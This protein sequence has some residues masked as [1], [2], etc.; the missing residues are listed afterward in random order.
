[1]IDGWRILL[2]AFA[3]LAIGGLAW[4]RGSL[5]PGGWAGAVLVGTITFG[6]GGWVWGGLLVGFFVSSS[7][8]T[9]WRRAAKQR[10][11]GARVEKGGRRDLGQVLANGGP[12]ALLA[13]AYGLGGEPAALLWLFLGVMATVTADTWATEI[14]M[15]DPAPPRLIIGL[16]PVSAGTSGAIS[17]YG[18][19]ATLAGAGLIG[20][21]A[22]LWPLA[23][24]RPPDGGLVP[25]ALLGG[26]AGSLCD[27]LLGAT[28]QASY[29]G[30]DG[31]TER[32]RDAH[33]APLPRLRGVPGLR[34]D[35]VNLLSSLLGGL[36]G[37]LAGAWLA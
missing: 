8:L 33:G 1:M 4:W 28:L 27:S 5:T 19:A 31:P 17:G 21:I 32:P 3:S 35:A 2:G 37:L 13:L 12:G 20:V 7:A 15:L 22:A 16:A 14:G 10:A 29:A 9:R 25:V 18:L 34:N 30:P 11:A 24:G 6:M 36:V 26:V 23:Q